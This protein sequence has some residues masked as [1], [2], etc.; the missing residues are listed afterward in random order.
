[1]SRIQFGSKVRVKSLILCS[2]YTALT[3]ST[4]LPYHAARGMLTHAHRHRPRPL[5]KKKAATDR[6]DK[7]KSES[8]SR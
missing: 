1:M 6:P 8:G 4:Y 2:E 3:S 7:K 5:N